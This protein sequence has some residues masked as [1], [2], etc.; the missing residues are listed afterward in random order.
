MK[1]WLRRR[2]RGFR[3]APRPH[4]W[5][6]R[7]LGLWVVIFTVLVAVALQRQGNIA[8]QAVDLAKQNRQANIRQEKTIRLL[9]SDL[10]IVNAIVQTAI[11]SAG[12]RLADHVKR[13][14]EAQAAADRNTILNFQQYSA[15]IIAQLTSRGSPCVSP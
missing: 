1:R 13:G 8:D 7:F 6:W 15:Q 2:W 10:Y 9:C 4:G 3:Y 5:R 12:L 14:L 11:E